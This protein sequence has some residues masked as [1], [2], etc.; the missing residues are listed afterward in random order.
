MP[1]FWPIYPSDFICTDSN[2]LCICARRE[3]FS[4]AH[5][6]IISFSFCLLYLAGK[7]DM[8][9]QE[10]P[11]TPPSACTLFLRTFFCRLMCGELALL[12][13]GRC[14]WHANSADILLFV[15]CVSLQPVLK[16]SFWMC[17]CFLVP[18]KK[19]MFSTE[20]VLHLKQ[21]TPPPIFTICIRHYNHYLE[22][23]P[24]GKYCFGEFWQTIYTVHGFDNICLHLMS[25]SVF[26]MQEL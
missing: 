3:R 5:C 17:L 19:V 18:L 20:C 1:S 16:V 15:Q 14:A 12:T 21:K 9:H 23:E 22:P 26:N 7:P 24:L 13:L 2:I 4:P 11:Q 8:P 10:G 25:I 6:I